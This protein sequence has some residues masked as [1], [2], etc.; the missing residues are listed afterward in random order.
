MKNLKVQNT[1][2]YLAGSYVRLIKRNTVS[3]MMERRQELICTF[4]PIGNGI[5]IAKITCTRPNGQKITVSVGKNGS[6]TEP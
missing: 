2:F 5:A 1:G 4:T 6:H 3:Q